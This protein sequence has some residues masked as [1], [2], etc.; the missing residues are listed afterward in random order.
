MRQLS[1]LLIISGL[2]IECSQNNIDQG[3]VT[4]NIH[5]TI[6]KVIDVDCG[7]KNGNIIDTTYF[8]QFSFKIMTRCQDKVCFIDTLTNEQ[9]TFLIRKWK[10]MEYVI[11]SNLY[12]TPLIINKLLFK[13]SLAS[14]LINNGFLTPPREIMFNAKDTSITFKTFIGHADSDVGDIYVMKINSKGKPKVIAILPNDMGE[15]D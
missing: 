12:L 13:D 9:D 7:W 14:D 1:I 4:S 8:D 2:F 11:N 6:Y 3:S 10:D 15:S 5:D